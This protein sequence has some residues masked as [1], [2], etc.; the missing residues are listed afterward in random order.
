[1]NHS[2]SVPERRFPAS[3]IMAMAKLP[4]LEEGSLCDSANMNKP[5]PLMVWETSGRKVAEWS[6]PGNVLGG[7][8]TAD[9]RLSVATTTADALHIWRLR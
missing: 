8:W 5:A 1:M 3:A 6:P 4:I 2:D 7:G 9:G